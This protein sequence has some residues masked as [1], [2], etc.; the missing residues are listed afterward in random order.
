MKHKDVDPKRIELISAFP[1]PNFPIK[2]AQ[3]S[4]SVECRT[5]K[6]IAETEKNFTEMMEEECVR[7]NK[8]C[9]W[10]FPHKHVV[11]YRNCKNNVNSYRAQCEQSSDELIKEYEL[12]YRRERDEDW[13]TWS[14]EYRKRNW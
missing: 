1:G 6:E 4:L 10:G 14:A 12:Y 5:D 11:V 3:T 13:Q 2:Q 9:F 8:E 7:L